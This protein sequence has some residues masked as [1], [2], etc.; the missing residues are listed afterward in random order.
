MG[1][2]L[3]GIP[4][5]RLLIFCLAGALC[6]SVVEYVHLLAGVWTLPAGRS[7]PPWIAVVYFFGLLGMGLLFQRRRAWRVAA[8][9]TYR[10]LLVELAA[11]AALMLL[12]PL[13]HRLE[14]LLV[15]VAGAFLAV[16]LWRFRLA[17]DVSFALA[18]AGV[19]LV[20]ELI[21]TA[22]SL[23]QYENASL[24]PLPLWLPLLWA[25][26]ALGLRRVHTWVLY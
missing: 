23:Y 12:P 15:L 16:R 21:M 19:D 7:F 20:L 6:G 24:G 5:R 13:L 14:L 11:L 18:V 22:A 26:L 17:G 1:R 2:L 3:R 10:T 8:T 4:S 25:G 9:M